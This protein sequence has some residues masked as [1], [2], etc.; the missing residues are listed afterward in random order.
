MEGA[1]SLDD[2]DKMW[3]PLARIIIKNH[4][5]R[6]MLANLDWRWFMDQYHAWH[7][8]VVGFMSRSMS[9]TEKKNSC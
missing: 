7:V 4:K 5:T 2:S 1:D 3:K 9:F 6:Q 8:T